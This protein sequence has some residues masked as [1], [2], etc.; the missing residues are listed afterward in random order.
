MSDRFYSV[1]EVAELL[2]IRQ[3]GVLSLIK[4]G[5]LSAI[6]VSLQPGGRPRWRITQ[7]DFEGFLARRTFQSPVPQRRRRRHQTAVT[8]FFK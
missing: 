2:G 1:R 7:E 6:D 5:Q 3:H 4:S 8:E